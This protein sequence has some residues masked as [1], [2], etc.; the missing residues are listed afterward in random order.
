MNNSNWKKRIPGIALGNILVLY[1][2]ILYGFLGHILS[3]VF[4]PHHNRLIALLLIFL[5]FASACVVRP[6]GGFIFGVI[7]DKY[8]RKSS[9]VISLLIMSIASVL[10]GCLPSYHA[11]GGVSV[12]LLVALRVLQGISMSGEEIGAS[13]YLIE[14]APKNRKSIAGS[15][16]L[17]SV[18][19]GLFLG[20]IITLLCLLFIPNNQLLIWG[21]RIPFLLSL[22]LGL[23]SLRLRIKQADSHSFIK[24][25]QKNTH[26]FKPFITVFEEYRFPLIFGIFIC[27]LEGI[28]IYV[29]AVFMPN[30]LA[31]YFHFSTTETLMFSCISFFIASIAIIGVGYLG[32]HIGCI[33]PLKTT[34]LLYV[35]A[36]PFIFYL[37]SRPCLP[38][39]MVAQLFILII[40]ALSSGTLLTTL[41]QVFPV[42]IRFTG[43]AI[44]FNLAMTIFGSTAPIIILSLKNL[45]A[46]SILPAFYFMLIGAISFIIITIFTNRNKLK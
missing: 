36:T 3:R 12:I 13:I 39:L 4:F 45:S 19:A 40:I 44:S 11:W 1:D 35:F 21:W 24:L 10:I 20:A 29:Y 43:T 9:L 31:G 42:N 26:L 7:G 37:I 33:L 18:H 23:I 41:S 25:K 15:I 30:Y 27:A 34:A 6:F 14:S 28:M 8:G 2:Y 17:A 5:V 32:D 46:I 38:C 16:V 22:P